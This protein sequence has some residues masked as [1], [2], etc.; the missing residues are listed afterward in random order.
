MALQAMSAF[1]RR[2][3]LPC[4]VFLLM[5]LAA[6][7]LLAQTSDTAAS[8]VARGKGDFSA[9]CAF[10]HGSQATGTEQAPNLLRSQLVLQDRN[11]DVLGPFLKTG[12]PASGMPSFASLSQLQISDIVAFLHAR[13]A[14]VQSTRLPESA[15]LVGDAKAGQAFFDGSGHCNTCHSPTGDLA[16]I[17]S[18]LQPLALTT[19]F[20]TPPAKQLGVTVTL[21]SG[22]VI[23][24]TLEYMDE[25]T[26]SVTDSSGRYH[27]WPRQSLRSVNVRDPLAAHKA[28]LPKYTDEDIHNLLAYLVTLK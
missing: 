13:A 21:L 9:S 10:C 22:A 12:R 15:L 17:G 28:L 23:S 16:G 4:A 6:E 19:A 5:G 1:V 26:V 11:G 8:A 7:S 2:H 3:S 27:S 20:L 14:E 24:G 25:F 18:R